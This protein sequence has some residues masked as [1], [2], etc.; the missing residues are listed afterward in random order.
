MSD[1]LF[2]ISV[3]VIF[4]SLWGLS[5]CL[6]VCLSTWVFVSVLFLK[7]SSLLS[8][9]FFIC[10][11]VLF[12]ICMSVLFS[13]FVYSVVNARASVLR[14]RHSA[15]RGT[16]L[17]FFNVANTDEKFI[18][19]F[20]VENF[21]T[22]GSAMCCLSLALLLLVCLTIDDCRCSSVSFVGLK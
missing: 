20:I 12:L 16:F 9:M 6:P 10:F 22:L 21:E 1:F 19:G 5:V 11:S 8:S 7:F 2:S 18:G 14:R 13:V 15:A 4:V 17:F 3:P